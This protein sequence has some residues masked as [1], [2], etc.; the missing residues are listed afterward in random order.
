M[1]T[2]TRVL[3]RTISSL[4]CCALLAGCLANPCG[5]SDE[6]WE[7]LEPFEQEQWR[8][9][10]LYWDAMRAEQERLRWLAEYKL[11]MRLCPATCTFQDIYERTF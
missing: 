5:L 1:R 3:C 10:D 2:I 11:Q 6:A 9:H 4:L 8:Q 7:G